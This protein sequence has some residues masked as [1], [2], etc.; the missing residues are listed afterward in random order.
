MNCQNIEQKNPFLTKLGYRLISFEEGMTDNPIEVYRRE[1]WQRTVDGQLMQLERWLK[2]G[3]E[4]HS[5]EYAANT[6]KARERRTNVLPQ[7]LS[8]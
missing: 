1:I 4:T 3:K 2:D 7:R 5:K 6:A 8:A